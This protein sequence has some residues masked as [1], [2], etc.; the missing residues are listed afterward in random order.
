[1]TLMPGFLDATANDTGANWCPAASPSY[2][3]QL[4]NTAFGTPGA[5]NV[6]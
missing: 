4:G 6:C 3:D 5:A 1:M 2:I